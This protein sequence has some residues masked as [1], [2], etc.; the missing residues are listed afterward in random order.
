[1]MKRSKHIPS[2]ATPLYQKLPR[3]ED[4][5][6]A[7]LCPVW[8][9]QRLDIGGPWCLGR[10]ANQQ[11]IIDILQRMGNWEQSTWAEIGRGG[12]HEI[13]IN[14]LEKQAQDRLLDL[15]LDDLDVLYSFRL[16]GKERLWGFRT[17]RHV[18]RVL[19]WDPDHEVCLSTKKHT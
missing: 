8:S 4:A 11:Q 19:W 2:S 3:A 7:S 9:F 17:D 15:K 18:V 1:M 6:S 12:S 13:P 5:V 10:T 16:S 14:K